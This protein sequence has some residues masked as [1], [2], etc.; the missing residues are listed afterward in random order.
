MLG[1]IE[2]SALLADCTKHT[3]DPNPNANPN[4]KHD[5]T[6]STNPNPNTMRS[7]IGQLCTSL[8]HTEYIQA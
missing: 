4:L 6:P 1:T 2:Q 7:P 5:P 3:M 8:D